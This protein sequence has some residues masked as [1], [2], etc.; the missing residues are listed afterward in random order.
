MQIHFQTLANEIFVKPSPLFPHII[1]SF[2]ARI[3]YLDI[4][5]ERDEEDSS[6]LLAKAMFYSEWTNGGNC[7]VR[8]Y[9]EDGVIR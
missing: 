8:V 1:S 5:H 7:P 3:I 9:K 6:I 2:T 4:S